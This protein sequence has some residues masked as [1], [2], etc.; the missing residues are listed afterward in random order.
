MSSRTGK[1]E[2][3]GSYQGRLLSKRARRE[4]PK[5]GGRGEAG[6]D[7]RERGDER[8]GGIGVSEITGMRQLEAKDGSNSKSRDCARIK[9]FRETR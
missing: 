2:I 6:R 3:G 7:G 5:G 4:R 1:E 8:V 9:P